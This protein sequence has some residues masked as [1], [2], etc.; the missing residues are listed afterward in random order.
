MNLCLKNSANIFPV[1]M[2]IGFTLAQVM[3]TFGSYV[4]GRISILTMIQ[5]KSNNQST[6]EHA[7]FLKQHKNHPNI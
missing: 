6:K 4:P 1:V 3:R 5:N 7:S 2:H